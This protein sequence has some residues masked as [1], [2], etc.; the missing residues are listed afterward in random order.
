MQ[1][2]TESKGR[3]SARNPL[4]CTPIKEEER[5]TKITQKFKKIQYLIEDKG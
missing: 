3:L 5:R 1:N 4:I 2:M